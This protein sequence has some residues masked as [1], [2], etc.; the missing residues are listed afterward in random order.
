MR[1]GNLLPEADL[2][3]REQTV[4]DTATSGARQREMTKA[5]DKNCTPPQQ[6]A[7]EVAACCGTMRSA[8]RL[9]T[10]GVGLAAV[11]V[12]THLNGCVIS[13]AILT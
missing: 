10:S 6:G 3:A 4:V 1:H 13:D 8:P 2:R 12:L 5:L 11:Q 7:A 9:V